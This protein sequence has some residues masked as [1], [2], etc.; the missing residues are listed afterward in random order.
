MRNKILILPMLFW[1]V[2]ASAQ[3]TGELPSVFSVAE[4][5]QVQFSQ[6]NL[7]Y[8]PSTAT[9]R[10]AEHQYDMIG[11]TNAKIS[12]SYTG[13]IDLFCWGTG[14]NPA[15]SAS[16][17]HK[18]TTYTEWGVNAISNGGNQAG[19]WRTLTK[20]E[21]VYLLLS[22]PNAATL[23]ALG[24]VSGVNGLILL[25]DNWQTP[26]GAS[27]VASSRK[28]FVKKSTYYKSA[29]QNG[30][31]HN[32]YTAEQWSAMESA[33]AVFMPAVGYRWGKELK[34][35]GASGCYWSSTPNEED[36]AE[37]YN[38]DFS[39]GYLGARSRTGLG[40]GQSVRLV[41]PAGKV[42]K[43]KRK[44]SIESLDTIPVPAT[45]RPYKSWLQKS[46]LF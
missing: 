16:D 26:E 43:P 13:W 39:A 45:V 24:K 11:A 36:E 8:Q 46:V 44:P 14:S 32:V 29:Q 17:Y 4:G 27:F 37:A 15:S 12:A 28:G 38:V 2:L 20:D 5:R 34:H 7:Q 21:W 22:R 6:G 42:A 25:P 41:C 31:S 40:F 33:G 9:W 3:N 10:F 35:T 23:C 30:Y 19:R 18:Y 1:A